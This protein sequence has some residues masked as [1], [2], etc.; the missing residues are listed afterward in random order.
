MTDGRVESTRHLRNP[1]D[2]LAQQV[3]A[4]TSVEP[5][6]VDALHAAV[7]GAAPF[8][9]LSRTVFESVLDLLSG[10]FASDDFAELRPRITWDRVA[11]TVIAR[12]G[13]KRIAIVN[14][15][16]IPD[17]GL[18]GVFL[19]GG[20]KA[21]A[22]VGELDEEMVFESKVGE[23]FLLG[24][25]SWRIEEITHDRVLVSP[26][27]GQPGKMPFWHGDAA[28]RPLETGQLIGRL[29]RELRGVAPRRGACRGW[30]AAT[31]S[32]DQAA[33]N[34]LQYLDDQAR[35]TGDVPDDR[36]LVVE[37]TRDELGD[38]RVCILS[39]LGGRVHAPWSMAL[40]ARVRD[41]LGLDV[42]TMWTND[43]FVVRFP[44]AERPPEVEHLLPSP[45]E[46]EALV[47]R[48]LGSTALFAAKFR[49]NA[50]RA[51][52]LPRRRPGQRTPLWQQRKRA[53]DLLAVAARFPTFPLLLETY[54]EC[55]RDVFDMPALVGTL[56]AVADRTMRVTTVD[57]AAPSPFAASLLFGFVANYIY[58]GDAPLAERRAQAL[59]IDQ[60]QLRELLGEAELRELLDA[61]VLA[62]VEA[63]LQQLDA[64]LPRPGHRRHPRPPAPGG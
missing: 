19:A 3:V 39:P 60:A 2:V 17:R 20:E 53:A 41:Q 5:W 11:N 9:D 35:A 24:A 52:L 30:S 40:T 31:S 1:L 55:L 33:E 6:G 47:L 54:R 64:P 59:S 8:A 56:R 27:P 44:D 50:S 16:T 37:R 22:R 7:R 15:G 48:Q 32:S 4:M 38:W 45:E 63:E 58:D 29:V 26:A 25:S 43:G 18:Y 28:A 42:E 34:L 12:E 21:H 51:L 61:D 62:A 10:R 23:V 49:E 46:V 14:G 36:T 13:A 57:T